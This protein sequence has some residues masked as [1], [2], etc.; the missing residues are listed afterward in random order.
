MVTALID[1]TNSYVVKYC[2]RDTEVEAIQWNG[3]DECTA[4]LMEWTGHRIRNA[5]GVLLLQSPDLIEQVCTGDYIVKRGIG[6]F[7]HWTP[8]ELAEYYAPVIVS[9]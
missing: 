6:A 8:L 4:F 3:S 1:R 9:A 7:H 5:N 2:A